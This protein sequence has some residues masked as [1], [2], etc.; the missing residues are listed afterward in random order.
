LNPNIERFMQSVKEERLERKVFFRES[1][2][3]TTA[4]QN[5][6]VIAVPL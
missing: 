5:T 3:H 2:L 4:A 1:S 6:I